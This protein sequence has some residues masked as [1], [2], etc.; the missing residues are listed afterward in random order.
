MS[1]NFFP[2]LPSIKEIKKKLYEIQKREE[3]LLFSLEMNTKTRRT[4]VKEEDARKI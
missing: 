3:W 2:P 4:R 1:A